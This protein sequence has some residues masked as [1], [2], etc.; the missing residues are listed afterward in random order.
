MPETLTA[1]PTAP[2]LDAVLARLRTDPAPSARAVW[3]TL[4]ASGTVGALYDG[5][6]PD[7]RWGLDPRRLRTLLT[8]LDT[9]FPLGT[10]L[11]FCV[12]AATA[13]PL[14][15]DAPPDSPAG[16]TAA[17]ALAGHAPWPWPSPTPRPPAR[18]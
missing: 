8:A 18:T 15:R 13:L 3:Q 17:Q 2:D 11:S 16:H 12:Q 4:A 7:T 6:T 9:A 14:L 5:P 10:T 1:R